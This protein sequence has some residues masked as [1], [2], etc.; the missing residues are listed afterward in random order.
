MELNP[1]AGTPLLSWRAPEHIHVRPN[2][3]GLM[4]STVLLALIIAYAIFTNSPIMAITFFLIGIVG[5]LFLTRDPREFEFAVTSKGI[6]G[7]KTLYD[8]EDIHSFWIYEESPLEGVLSLHS[9][10]IISPYIHIPIGDVPAEELRNLLL[11]YVPE[12]KHEPT[13]I[14]TLEKMLHI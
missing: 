14:D 7:G 2:P 5:Y 4:V 13:I 6:L 8:F 3:R 9:N 11:D 12:E 10:G 1:S